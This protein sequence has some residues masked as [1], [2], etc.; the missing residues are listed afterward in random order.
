[1][2]TK[3]LFIY[4]IVLI[5]LL[6]LCLVFGAIFL[7]KFYYDK[8]PGT[9]VLQTEEE[10]V[11]SYDLPIKG[12]V[13]MAGQD[14]NSTEAIT[15]TVAKVDFKNEVTLVAS[16]PKNYVIKTKLFGMIPLKNVDVNIV[17]DVQVI[18][19]GV[20]VGVYANTDGLLVVQTGEF[21]GIDGSKCA[22]C[23]KIISPG[24][25]IKKINGQE[26][27]SKYQLVSLIEKCDGSVQTLTV[28][29]GDKIFDVD[30]VPKENKSGSYKLGIWVKDNA[31]GIGTLTFLTSNG[32]FGALGH[33]IIDIDV[34]TV[35]E[36]GDGN[37]YR[38]E[39]MG[40]K[41]SERGN[42]G[43]MTGVIFYGQEPLGDILYN[44]E[45]GIYGEYNLDKIDY[46]LRGFEDAT[47]SEGMEIA[48]QN[49]IHEGNAEILCTING[50]TGLYDVEIDRIYPNAEN[51][52]KSLKLTVKDEELLAITGGIVQ[53][54]SGSPIIQDGKIV[55]AVTHVLV[56]DPTRGYG[57][58]IENM[59]EY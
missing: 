1:M 40:I 34:Q 58:F 13:Y 26:L 24:D 11:L 32:E 55:G 8:L 18:P 19:I 3:S 43:E 42:P 45:S 54:M 10:V 15:K 59:L 28:R 23:E 20:P 44:Y 46:L 50:K 14:E 57:I 16:R 48:Y 37:L 47:L 29:R 6:N 25:Y 38:A 5:I 30:V 35:L 49:E 39:I 4:R 52:N 36:I 17:D 31:Q 7:Y 27:E 2:K 9:I 41:K 12:I 53:G 22:P 33:G 21:E 56:N 51:I